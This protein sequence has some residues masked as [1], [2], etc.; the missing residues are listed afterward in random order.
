MVLDSAFS[1]LYTLMM[2]LVDVYKIRLPKFT[3]K[4]AV[5]YMR[6]VIEKKAK[7]DIMDLKLLPAAAK[8]FT[9]A[10]FAHANDDKFIQPHH[11]E[12]ISKVYAGD[13]K[14]IR[15]A[16]DHNSSRPQSF[17]DSVAVFFCKVLHPPLVPRNRKLEKYFNLGSLRLGSGLD[18]SLLFEILSSL[19][20]VDAASSSSSAQNI[21]FAESGSLLSEAGLVTTDELNVSNEDS[22]SRN[23]S[24]RES[25]GRCS[26]L[27]NSDDETTT[28]PGGENN[29]AEV[30]LYLYLYL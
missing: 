30:C 26:I 15:F 7:F 24:T 19:R 6:R 18:E 28:D 14:V 22:F 2:E 25:W 10:L 21:S 12:L 27:G 23:S 3:V 11:S 1:N 20:S 9:P 17:F 29:A 16:G 5:Q 13:K 8:I 4:M